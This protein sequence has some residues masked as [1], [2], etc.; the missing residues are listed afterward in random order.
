MDL[1]NWLNISNLEIRESNIN[2]P[3]TEK[4][5]RLNPKYFTEE[6]IATGY[7]QGLTLD[8]IEA[9]KRISNYELKGLFV[10]SSQADGNFKESSDL[11]II[12]YR[13]AHPSYMERNNLVLELEDKYQLFYQGHKKPEDVDLI[14][15]NSPFGRLYDL[16]QNVWVE[17]LKKHQKMH[18]FQDSIKDIDKSLLLSLGLDLGKMNQYFWDRDN[19][20]AFSQLSYLNQ[21]PLCRVKE[22]NND[23]IC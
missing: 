2:F 9:W 13:N 17:G 14:I 18:H 19:T 22:L 1:T 15:T 7:L 5:L 4:P 21:T 6:G 11:D 8:I 3:K 12:I 20:M 23:R 16:I 10:G